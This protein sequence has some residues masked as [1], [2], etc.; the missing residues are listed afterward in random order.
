MDK[1]TSMTQAY[2]EAIYYTETGDDGQPGGNAQL[3]DLCKAQAW[4]ACRSFINAIQGVTGEGPVNGFDDL[5]PSQ[6]G[7]DLWLTR[8]GH[9]TGFWD[10]D[11][12]VYSSTNATLFCRLAAAMGEHNA[13]FE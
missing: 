8:N 13:D 7:H 5:D 2:I 10:R 1:V 11:P 3:T 4:S 6:L 9:G 12:S